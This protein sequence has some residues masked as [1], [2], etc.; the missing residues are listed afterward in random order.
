MF[1]WSP[2][3]STNGSSQ[4]PTIQVEETFDEG[5]YLDNITGVRT[6]GWGTQPLRGVMCLW[7]E[8]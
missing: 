5:S 6:K 1:I 4:L 8:S 7:T 3:P 2:C